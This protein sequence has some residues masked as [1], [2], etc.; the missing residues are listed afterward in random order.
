LGPI[1]FFF[2]FGLELDI[3]PLVVG[4][5]SDRRKWKRF[6]KT[7]TDFLQREKPCEAIDGGHGGSRRPATRPPKTNG[8][9]NA[10]AIWV[11]VAASD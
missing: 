1:K 5:G 4:H 8:R 9:E 6:L 11:N 3:V 10:L 7:E 2:G